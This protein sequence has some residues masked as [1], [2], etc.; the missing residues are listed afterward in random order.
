LKDFNR[1]ARGHC[2]EE[3]LCSLADCRP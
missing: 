3:D 1:P 2:V